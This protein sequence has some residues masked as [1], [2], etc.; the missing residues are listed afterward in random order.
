MRFILHPLLLIRLLLQSAWLALGQIWANKTRSVLTTIGII[1]GVSS[2]TAVIAALTGLRLNVLG[3]FES[4]GTN[5]IYIIP[6][7]PKT[8]PL[9]NS[10]QWLLRFKPEEFDSLAEHCPSV[11]NFT[12]TVS[13]LQD[14]SHREKTEGGVEVTGIDAPW[15]Q[16][17]NRFVTQGRPFTLIDNVQARPVCLINAKLRD[18]LALPIEC[19]G[20]TIMVGEARFTILGLIEPRV[21]SSMFGGGG[22]ELEVFIPFTRAWRM[23]QGFIVGLAA[24]LARGF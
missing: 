16:I 20:E 6:D 2:V 10:N 18:K 23:N 21:E 19:V 24:S 8:G 13:N 22:T 11:A 1:I 12:R 17:E 3:Q 4:F 9:K 14:V 5:K 7:R 15:H